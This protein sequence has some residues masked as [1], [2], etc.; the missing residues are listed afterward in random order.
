MDSTKQV[1]R[2]RLERISRGWP[3]REVAEKMGVTVATITNWETGR[4]FPMVDQAI[5]LS[6]IYDVPVR[7]L[8]S[9]LFFTQKV[10]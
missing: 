4:T 5:E 7:D 3:M 9:D 2:L 1:S 6:R 10:K 8:F